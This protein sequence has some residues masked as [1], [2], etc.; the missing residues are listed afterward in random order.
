MIAMR[1]GCVPV[2][3]ATGGLTDTI[4]D[5]GTK[6]DTGFL[7]DD[8]T[9]ES[10]A[11]A[12]SRVLERFSSKRDWQSLQLNGMRQDFSWERSAQKYLQEYKKLLSDA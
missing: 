9:P 4:I 12:L 6:N 2:A 10:L 5:K 11:D 7:F 3:R 1:Y 8:A